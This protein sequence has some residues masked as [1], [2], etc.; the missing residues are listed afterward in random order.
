MMA[1]WVAFA[2]DGSPLAASPQWPR[3]TAPGLRNVMQWGAPL[4]EVSAIIDSPERDL[5]RIY[6]EKIKR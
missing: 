4:N 3:F 6:G 2:R 5:C 1:T